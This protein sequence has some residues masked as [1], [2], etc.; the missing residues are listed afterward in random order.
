MPVPVSFS[1]D[2]RH[3]EL[4]D[5]LSN[6]HSLWDEGEAFPSPPPLIGE[7]EKQLTDNFMK[8]A[9]ASQP[10]QFRLFFDYSLTDWKRVMG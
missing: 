9:S 10:F 8:R 6:L 4:H 3:T 1:S 2:R 7:K 5:I